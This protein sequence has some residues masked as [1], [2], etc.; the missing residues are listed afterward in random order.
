MLASFP[1]LQAVN[2]VQAALD[3]M[4]PEKRLQMEGYRPGTYVRLHFS[5]NATFPLSLEPTS[6]W[7]L[8]GTFNPES[9]DKGLAKR[10]LMYYRIS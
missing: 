6:M 8:P 2:V 4:D 1:W 5:G 9:I 10:V 3:A 7:Q